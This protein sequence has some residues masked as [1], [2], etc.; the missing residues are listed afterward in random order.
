MLPNNLICSILKFVFL[1][2]CKF[3]KNLFLTE[4]LNFPLKKEN[5]P[6]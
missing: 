6:K 1:M 2:F 5:F 3:L 4:D